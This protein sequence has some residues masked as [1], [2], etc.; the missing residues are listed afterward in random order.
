MENK[1]IILLVIVVA[2]LYGLSD[3][4]HQSFTPGREP[5]VRDMV[6]DSVG[7]FIFLYFIVKILP[8]TDRKIVKI[9]DYLGFIKK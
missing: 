5:T 3:E 2:F 9:A 4:F 7:A 6:I 8:N 1:N